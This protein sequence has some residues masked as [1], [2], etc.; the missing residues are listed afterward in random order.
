MKGKTLLLLIVLCL[1]AANLSSN[2]IN[3]ISLGYAASLGGLNSLD[4]NLNVRFFK[5][6]SIEGI[7]AG[8]LVYMKDDT[9]EDDERSKGF[10]GIGIK[11]AY[12]FIHSDRIQL[13]GYGAAWF[14]TQY[15]DT[16]GDSDSFKHNAF[17]LGLGIQT[18]NYFID[19]GYITS[20]YTS[21]IKFRVGMRF[22]IYKKIHI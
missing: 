11:G 16:I 14:L 20:E 9:L 2:E 13:Y 8:G 6:F 19:L 12:H 5:T 1:L 3:E 10:W 4:L 21:S 18:T 22:F 7:L 15:E 17:E